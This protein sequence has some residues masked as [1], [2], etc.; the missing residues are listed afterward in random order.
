MSQEQIQIP[1]GWEQVSL[2]DIA[3]V[4]GGKRVPKGHKLVMEKTNHPYLSVKNLKNN[5]VY[6]NNIQ[7]VS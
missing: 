7:S 1:K 2:D 5:S 3:D 6:E 4:K